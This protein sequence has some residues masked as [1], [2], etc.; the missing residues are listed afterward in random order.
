MGFWYS[1]D[2]SQ[3][4][5]ACQSQLLPA[6]WLQ[7]H[8]VIFIDTHNLAKERR[9]LRTPERKHLADSTRQPPTQ[10]FAVLGRNVLCLGLTRL[11]RPA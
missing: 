9:T 11:R 8:P 6:S 5:R 10:G 7:Q 3:K 1:G 4:V 2:A